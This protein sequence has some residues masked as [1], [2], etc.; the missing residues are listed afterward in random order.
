MSRTSALPLFGWSALIVFAAGCGRPDRSPTTSASAGASTPTVSVTSTPSSETVPAE[1]GPVS[2]E[3]AESTFNDGR[4]A[5]ATS[6]FTAYTQNSPE[7]PWG[8]YMLGVSA[9]RTGDHDRAIGAFDRA[10]ELDPDHRKSLFNSSRVLL[11]TGQPKAALERIE[12]ALSKEPMSNEGLR[13]LGRV[14]YQLGQVPE[15]VDAYRRA[16]TIDEQD[17]WA[18]NNLGLIYLDQGRSEEALPPLARAVELKP[19]APVFQNNLGMALERSGYPT[20][21]AQAYE[22]AIA[23]DSTYRKAGVG[24]SRVTDGS[25][26]AESSPVDLVALAT[27]F[28]SEI[29]TWRGATTVIDST[30]SAADTVT[31]STVGVVEPVGDSG[32]LSIEVSSDTLED[33]TH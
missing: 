12:K 19:K 16:L 23:V 28:Q 14:R 11:E 21:A 2:Y 17:V 1:T 10:L 6:L 31:D 20:A 25:Q 32:R 7:N 5:E 26:Q 4:Y 29:E 8:H 24:L 15:A 33:C 18:M 3:K 13:L 9:W 27:Q 30:E 22:A